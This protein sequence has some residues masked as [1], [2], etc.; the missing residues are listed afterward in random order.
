MKYKRLILSV[1]TL[2]ISGAVF[3]HSGATG[4]VKQRMDA[5]GDMGAHGGRYRI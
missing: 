5:M 3:A 4:V 1:L 2:T